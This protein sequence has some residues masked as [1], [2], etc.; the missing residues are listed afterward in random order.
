MAYPQ[1]DMAAAPAHFPQGFFK[2]CSLFFL[3]IICCALLGIGATVKVTQEPVFASTL[4]KGRQTLSCS[5]SESSTYN[6]F[7]YR[8]LSGGKELEHIGSL[9]EFS[10]NLTESEGWLSGQWLENGKKMSLELQGPQPSDTGLYLC[11]VRDTVRQ[12]GTAA[13]AKPSASIKQPQLL[14]RA[15]GTC[16]ISLPT[17]SGHTGAII[18]IRDTQRKELRRGTVLMS[19][20]RNI[21]SPQLM[22]QSAPGFPNSAPSRRFFELQP[23]LSLMVGPAG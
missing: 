2:L 3:A 14:P 10:E 19:D 11:A 5:H 23:A 13:G 1:T 6:F 12:A 20:V 7:W 8:Q 16:P 17:T 9:F 4:Q 15:A 18:C 22:K 21:T